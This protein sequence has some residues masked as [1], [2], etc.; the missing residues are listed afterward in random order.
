M[1]VVCK[2]SQSSAQYES[3]TSYS[4]HH[5]KSLGALICEWCTNIATNAG[6]L[7]LAFTDPPLSREPNAVAH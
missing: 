7:N 3:R 1:G 6:N 5:E 2:E 4:L